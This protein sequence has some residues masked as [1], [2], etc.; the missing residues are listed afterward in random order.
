MKLSIDFPERV[1]DSK[2]KFFSN[3]GIREFV[4]AGIGLFVGFFIL[5]GLPLDLMTR[6]FIT[7]LFAAFVYFI[8]KV[9]FRG[10]TPEKYLYIIIKSML[11]PKI[12][13]HMTSYYAQ[14]KID[15]QPQVNPEPIKPKEPPKPKIEQNISPPSDNKNNG[16]WISIEEEIEN[17]AILI[18]FSVIML[19][20]VLAGLIYFYNSK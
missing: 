12:Y 3:F 11:G 8:I 13:I 10:Y 1:R 20:I 14:P 17:S 18:M 19:F 6:M 9:N 4:I 5:I 16:R 15:I 7:G 2:L